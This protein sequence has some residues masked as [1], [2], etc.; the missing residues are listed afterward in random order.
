MGFLWRSG[1]EPDLVHVEEPVKMVWT[2]ENNV[3]LVKCYV[4]RQKALQENQNTLKIGLLGWPWDTL[5]SS[6]W[7]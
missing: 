4:D 1:V 5:V 6:L 3:F 7:S 2:S